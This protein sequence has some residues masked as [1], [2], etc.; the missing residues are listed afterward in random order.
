MSAQDVVTMYRFRYLALGNEVSPRHMWG[1]R[2]AIAT[3]HECTPLD[4]TAREISR[5]LVDLAGFYYEHA[6][7]VFIDIEEPR[8]AA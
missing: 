8:R 1:T 7:S 3:L 6:P 5:D 2:E 4:D